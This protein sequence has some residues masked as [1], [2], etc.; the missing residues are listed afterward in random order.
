[1]DH[2]GLDMYDIYDQEDVEEYTQYLDY[3]EQYQALENDEA[4]DSG[5]TSGGR[6][7]TKTYPENPTKY[8]ESKFR[9]SPIMKCTSAIPQLAYCSSPDA[10][11][12]YLQIGE[13]CSHKY[14]WNFTKCIYILY[15]GEFLRKP[16][17]D[18]VQHVYELH[19]NKHGLPGMLRSIDCIHWECTNCPKALH[20][21]FKRHDHKYPTIMLEAVADQQLWIWHAYFEVPEANNDLNVLYGTPLFED[22]LFVKALEAPFVDEK[23]MNFKRVQESSRKDVERAFRVLQGHWGNYTTIRTYKHTWKNPKSTQERRNRGR[24]IDLDGE[25]EPFGDDFIPRPSGVPRLSKSQR[26]SNSSATYCS[27][28]EQF[29]NM[30]QQQISKDRKKM[31]R[32]ERETAARLE[33]SY[34]QKRNEDLKMLALDT[35]GMNPT[36]A[37]K[38]EEMKNTM[39]AKKI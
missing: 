29:T 11:D 38:I 1:M 3:F 37:S 30:L 24:L 18:D 31:E 33:V 25:P 20:G 35:T 7:R 17:L 9:L 22:I 21:Q 6:R 15:V 28:K 32:I 16:N 27:N 10:F 14:L 5:A 19:E 12:E 4:E 34:A 2:N 8:P 23:T 36:G 26:S 39:Q 13:R